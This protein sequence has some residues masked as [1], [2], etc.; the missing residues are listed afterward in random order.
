MRTTQ[1]KV[2]TTEIPPESEHQKRT[3]DHHKMVIPGRLGVKGGGTGCGGKGAVY[4]KY[5][6][7][8]IAGALARD[9][10]FTYE[11]LGNVFGVKTKTVASWVAI[12]PEFKKAVVDGR[13]AFD[14]EKVENAL[15]KRAMGY[16]F[17]EVR[18]TRV[19]VKARDS[20]GKVVMVPAVETVTTTKEIP[21]DPKSAIF[22]LSNRM[23]ERWQLQV[24]VNAKVGGSVQHNHNHT[25]VV[26][27]AQLENLN[28]DQL[29]ALR[30][31]ISAQKGDIIELAE[32]EDQGQIEHIL[33]TIGMG[34][35][36]DYADFTE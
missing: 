22:W 28:K 36:D 12:Y 33:D 14:G 3:H 6:F 30:D 25:G 23:K 13:D 31:M 1:R 16:E 8:Q 15:L 21:P 4:D 19:R 18:K 20:E 29:L 26:A 5:R 11:Q 27:S 32:N 35:D 24:N 2:T 7:P 9:Y 10:G 34:E 17:T